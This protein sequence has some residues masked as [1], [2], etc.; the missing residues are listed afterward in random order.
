MGYRRSI[1]RRWSR[2]DW[3]TVL[4]IA[5]AS[6]FLVGTTL[7]L[8]TAGTHAATVSGDLETS[9]A[10]TYHESVNDA[11]AAAGGEAIVFP[12]AVVSDDGTDHTVVGIPPDAPGELEDAS[13]SWEA[14]TVPPPGD[15]GTAH[16]PVSDEIEMRFDGDDGTASVTVVPHHEETIFPPWWYTADVSTVE[17]LGSTGA[18]V[19]ETG[20]EVTRKDATLLS[21]DRP[22][23]GVPLVSKLAFLFAGMHEVLRVLA[24]A[25]AGGAVIVAVVLYSVTRIGVRERL[26]TIEMIRST[27]GTPATVLALYGLRSTLIATVGVVGGFAIG[28]ITT[29]LS[30]ELA[31]RAGVPVTLEPRVTLPTLQVLLP[32]SVTLV[33]VGGLAGVIAA[34]PAAKGPPAALGSR[35][36]PGAAPA[37]IRRLDARLPPELSP[38]LLDWR[39]VVPTAA[40]LAVFVALVLLISGIGAAVAPVGDTETGTVTSADAAH[41]IDSRLD[42]GIADSLRDEGIEA[43]P[44]IVLAQVSDGQPYLARGANYD[45]FAAVTGAELVDGREPTAPDEAVIGTEIARTLDV[46]VGD[47][48]TL[49]GSDHPA[50]ARVTIVGVYETDG[51]MDDQLVVPLE[52]G[53]HLSLEPGTVH[54]IRTA[55]DV[56]T[57]FEE[58][59]D[60]PTEPVEDSV[61]RNVGT[62]ETAVVD[63]PMTIEVLVHN[64]ESTEITRTIDI[65]AG[66]DTY[67]RDVTLEPDE[68]RRIEIEHAFGSAGDRTVAAGGHSSTVT[69]LAADA[70]VLPETLPEEAPPGATLLVR[71]TTPTGEPVEDATLAIDD[72]QATT[73]ADGTTRIDLPEAEGE[74]DLE[75]AKP[76]QEDTTHGIRVIEDRER[77]LGADLEIEPRTGTPD[78]DPEVT[79]TLANHWTDE[80]TQDV[81]VVSPTGEQ[82][83]TVTLGPDESTTMERTL[84]EEG[85]DGGI[86]PGEYEI[87]VLADDDPIAIQEYDVLDGDFDLTA[88]PAEG[89]Y[90]SGAAMGHVVENTLGNI[91]LLLTTMVVLAGLM[92]IGSTTAAFAQAVHA[93]HEA[94]AIHRST[95]A[96]PVW[97]SKIV[98]LDACKL[99]IPAAL[100]AAA[101]ALV[102]IS[103]LDRAGLLSVFG[104]RFATGAGPLLL[105]LALL[106]AVFIAVCSAV[107][108]L[109]PALFSSPA[110]VWHGPSRSG[111]PND[112]PAD[113]RE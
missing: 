110:A 109:L 7:L 101:V 79:V 85:S 68:E 106:G 103:V 46:E 15:P 35:S 70:L 69:V 42:A 112:I 17:A 95:G 40:T 84:G 88:A 92:T 13:T 105:L 45:E 14:A 23:S 72:E 30:V 80:R 9:T 52:T 61:I 81:T 27:G 93:R 50:V 37:H 62:P 99:A 54:V 59:D 20:A 48:L 107:L 60:E 96:S 64:D 32:M 1:L 5:V 89:Q 4:I 91:R 97:V 43:S 16:G 34:R 49:G 21:F 58:R 56:G 75:A 65:D 51:P 36:E 73:A 18:I 98:V 33:A 12:I 38:T 41:P 71:V 87:V 76:D 44:E 11:E 8:L 111:S 66:T 94:I 82:T 19:V 86:P 100:L 83:R 55:G 29:N 25:T 6:A 78:T 90:H 31:I 26:K 57:V 67:E 74:Y 22:D 24:V 113:E 2:R 104:V 77:Q 47:A 39:T 102:A 10:A 53:H 28:V 3:L 108:A 63:E